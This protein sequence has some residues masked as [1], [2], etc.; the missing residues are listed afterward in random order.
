MDEKTGRE[1]ARALGALEAGQEN[2]IRHVEAVSGKVDRRFAE[3]KEEIKGVAEA[4]AE[5]A[6]SA[7]AHQLGGERRGTG[8]IMHA[9]TWVV[10][11]LGGLAGLIAWAGKH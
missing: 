5:H 2:L 4:L 11:I 1:I 9:I 6:K 10:G 7:D 8:Q 3:A